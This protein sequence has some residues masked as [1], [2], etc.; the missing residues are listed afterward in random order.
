MFAVGI[1]YVFEQCE[2][3]DNLSVAGT[4]DVEAVSLAH[5]VISNPSA[6]IS[7]VDDNDGVS[8]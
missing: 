3:S 1:S 6:D 7:K 5:S 8:V 2:Q 4:S